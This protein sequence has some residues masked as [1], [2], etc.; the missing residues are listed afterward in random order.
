LFDTRA[1]KCENEIMPSGSHGGGHGGSHSGGGSRGGY[2][3]GSSFGGSRSGSFGGG[4]GHGFGRWSRPRHFYFGHRH[5]YISGGRSRAISG[6]GLVIGI[7]I[8]FAVIGLMGIMGA[9]SRIKQ[10]KTDY[11]YYQSM[12]Q[13]A[14]EDSNY[15][16]T[17]KVTGKFQSD[18]CDRW[19]ITYEIDFMES[20]VAKKLSGFS[21]SV[22]I[23]GTAPAVASIIDVALDCPSAEITRDTDSVPMDY[24][25][26]PI[27]N[28]GEYVNELGTKQN[29]SF[30]FYGSLGA[31][32]LAVLVGAVLA[33][34]RQSTAE[35]TAAAAAGGIKDTATPK[36]PTCP[37]CGTKFNSGDAKC[38]T[39]GARIGQ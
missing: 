2:G 14:S 7:A 13:L 36:T 37:Y 34:A 9:D 35:Q 38:P 31:I 28:D 10:I 32:A 30:A 27:T 8:F 5:F 1:E 15:K 23:L 25:G 24:L 29:M 17:A 22:Y 33:F 16:T 12:A 20:G 39:C 6:A 19:Y 11:A 4:Y 3:G 18:T 21:Y 26:M